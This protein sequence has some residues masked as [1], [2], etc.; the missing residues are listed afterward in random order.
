MLHNIFA[1]GVERN[2]I[3]I[4]TVGHCDKDRD[5]FKVIRRGAT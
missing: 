4:S 2:T 1:Y 3:M 5:C